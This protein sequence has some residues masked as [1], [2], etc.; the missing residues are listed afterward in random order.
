M[1]GNTL[2]LA[3]LFFRP[4]P[5]LSLQQ[6]KGQPSSP[7]L[8]DGVLSVGLGVTLLRFLPRCRSYMLR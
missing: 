7:A 1:L 8:R 2:G 6:V 5:D 3:A 4:G